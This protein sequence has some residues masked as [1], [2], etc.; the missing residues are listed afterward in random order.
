MPKNDKKIK[1]DPN[2]FALAI[3]GANTKSDNENNTQFAKKEL[4]LYLEGYLLANDFNNLEETQFDLAKKNKV[5]E[6]MEK[7]SIAR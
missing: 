5:E 1:I 6:I 3:V 4:V 2:E 7:I